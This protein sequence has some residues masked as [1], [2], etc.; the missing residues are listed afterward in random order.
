MQRQFI[1]D[2]SPW[3]PMSNPIDLMVAGKLAEELGECVASVSRC[4]IQGI[5]ECEPSTGEPNRK[6][7]EKEIADVLANAAL[8]V[9]R[10]ALNQSF[11]DERIAFKTAYLRKWHSME[12]SAYQGDH[13]LHKLTKE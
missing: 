7:L 4:I 9:E 13:Q 10:F 5:D 3:I 2:A 6:W 11:I 1:P 12:G 8:V